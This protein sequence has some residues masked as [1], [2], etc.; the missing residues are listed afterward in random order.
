MPLRLRQPVST[1]MTTGPS[2]PVVLRAAAAA[3]PAA[4]AAA[5][6]AAAAAAALAAAATA[7]VMAA[8]LLSPGASAVPSPDACFSSL[9][10]GY[11]D[12]LPVSFGGLDTQCCQ[13]HSYYAL[14]NCAGT[15]CA[16][17]CYCLDTAPTSQVS[18]ACSTCAAD[19][20][21][22]TCSVPYLA[23][24]V[25][26]APEAAASSSSLALISPAATG[27]TSTTSATVTAGATA[28]A[29]ATQANPTST[30]STEGNSSA[31]TSGGPGAESGDS[32]DSSDTVTS[33]ATNPNPSVGAPVQNTPATTSTSTSQSS[34]SSSGISVAGLGAGVASAVV[35]VALVIAAA[36]YFRRRGVSSPQSPAS[37][38]TQSNNDS[39]ADGAKGAS[40]LSSPPFDGAEGSAAA[41][42]RASHL[43]GTSDATVIRIGET[44]PVGTQAKPSD[45]SPNLPAVD[46]DSAVAPAVVPTVTVVAPPP[47]EASTGEAY[48][49]L[50]TGSAP[51]GL[52]QY[53]STGY[54]SS[55]G[56]LGRERT[57]RQ[58]QSATYK[59]FP[60][61]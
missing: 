4:A 16:L 52:G 61:G 60:D 55:T 29:S 12:S 31:S 54:I 25:Y 57:I 35:F 47:D 14:F 41:A 24:A 34:T 32:S 11:P 45:Q 43:S 5:P 30:E 27:L 40:A 17:Q 33:T 39:G 3:A 56:L 21:T 1:A 23:W 50:S 19:A 42:A 26:F 48:P 2:Q 18:T 22:L 9:D 37:I 15:D 49:S 8:V 20:S 13:G 44:S 7:A 10:K 6:A 38:Q 58:N 46:T 53:S 36:L 28:T 51:E 59:D